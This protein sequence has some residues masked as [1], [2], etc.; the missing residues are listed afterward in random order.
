MLLTPAG[1]PKLR[2]WG[3]RDH[4]RA[5]MAA[6][7]LGH[8]GGVPEPVQ[9]LGTLLDLELGMAVVERTSQ[10]QPRSLRGLQSE[11]LRL[12]DQPWSDSE[13]SLGL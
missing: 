9:A 6:N 1:A 12:R 5:E 10:N 3:P 4:A 7:G 11:K 8:Q 13:D 2:V